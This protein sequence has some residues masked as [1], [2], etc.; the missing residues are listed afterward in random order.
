LHCYCIASAWEIKPVHGEIG[1]T[2]GTVTNY[3]V[4]PL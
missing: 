4:R 3:G 1:D 2:E